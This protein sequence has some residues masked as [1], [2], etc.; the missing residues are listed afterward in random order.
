MDYIDSIFVSLA[1]KKSSQI[2]IIACLYTGVRFPTGCDSMLRSPAPSVG[3]TLD[4]AFL[5]HIELA[6]RSN[7]AVHDGAI[8]I[9]RKSIRERYVIRGWS[10]RLF[11]SG[12]D[13]RP[14][15]N[16]GSAFNSCLAMS[17]VRRVD[18]MLLLS[19]GELFKF[20]AGKYR[21]LST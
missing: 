5:D 17:G 16:R 4:D 9:G 12:L 19:K 10:F 6:I 3:A 11:P 13:S 20:V 21:L 14:V 2:P 8:M 18:R 1:R 7:P 15:P